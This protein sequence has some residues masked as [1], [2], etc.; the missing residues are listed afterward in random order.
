MLLSGS[1]VW[2]SAASVPANTPGA[3][4]THILSRRLVVQV[5]SRRPPGSLD[6]LLTLHFSSHVILSN[7]SFFLSSFC[8]FLGVYTIRD[9][10]TFTASIMA[11]T[12]YVHV[13]YALFDNPIGNVIGA[14]LVYVF[15]SRVC[16]LLRVRSR[17][18]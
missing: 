4:S 14:L 6:S 1:A 3:S 11:T 17:I 2:S 13:F 5:A 7:F 9:H 8:S 16:I 15:F 10:T 12:S 18:P